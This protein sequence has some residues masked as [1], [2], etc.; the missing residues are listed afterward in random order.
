MPALSG[1]NIAFSPAK[2]LFCA[3]IMQENA[4]DKSTNFLV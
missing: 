1:K 3:F 4:N 2:H